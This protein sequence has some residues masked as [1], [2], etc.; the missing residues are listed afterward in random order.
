MAKKYPHPISFRISTEQYQNVMELMKEQN[1]TQ[2]EL[3]R[4][5]TFKFIKSITHFKNKQNENLNPVSS[6][7]K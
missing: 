2:S 1:V 7:Q 4:Y 6:T 3:F 5:M